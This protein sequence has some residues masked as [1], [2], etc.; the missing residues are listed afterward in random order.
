MASTAIGP[1]TARGMGPS[2]MIPRARKYLA[3]LP[4]R[5]FQVQTQ[6]EFTAALDRATQRF[7]KSLPK[8]ARHWGAARKFLNIY[9]RDLVYNRFLCEHYRLER[10]EPWLELPLDSHVAKGLRKERG[11]SRVPRWKTVI[12]LDAK[13]NDEYQ[14][15]ASDVARQK[16]TSRIHLDIIYWRSSFVVG[17]L[18]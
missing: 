6:K 8:G 14:T 10:I 1:S 3:G 13:L 4:V 17:H 15:F 5:S 2:G 18:K 12:G 9:L 11:G 7:V 16:H